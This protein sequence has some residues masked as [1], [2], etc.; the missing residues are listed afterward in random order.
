MC[1]GHKGVGELQRS[2]VSKTPEPRGQAQVLKPML[3]L[4]SM[5]GSVAPSLNRH[6]L[7]PGTWCGGQNDTG[8]QAAS[9]SQLGTCV[10]QRVLLQSLAT[11]ARSLQVHDV[12]LYLLTGEQRF[13]VWSQ[14]ACE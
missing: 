11:L 2:K 12:A 10:C 8:F 14:K 3:N 7:S 6:R 9:H 13:C 4:F 5:R 1:Q